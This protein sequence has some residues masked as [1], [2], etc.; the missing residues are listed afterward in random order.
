MKNDSAHYRD[1]KLGAALRELEVPEHRE[2][3]FADLETRLTARRRRP[4][5]RPLAVAAAAGVALLLFV[6]VGWPHLRSGPGV[7]SAAAVRAEVLKTLAGARTIRGDLVYSSFDLRTGKT[8]TR[9]QTFAADSRGDLRVTDVGGPSDLAYDAARGV[10]RAVTTSASIGAGRFFA[11]RVGVA[12]GPPDHGPSSF[13]L[14]RALGSVVRALAAARSPQVAEASYRGRAAWRLDTPLEPNTIFA[15]ADRLQVTVDRATGFPVHVL[16]TLRGA[17]R[18]E[19]RVDQLVVD[20]ALPPDTFTVDFPTGAD[21]LRTDEGF[22]HVS[23]D[24]AAA[25]VGYRPLGPADVPEGFGLTTIAVAKEAAPT[26]PGE[27]NPPSRD[28]VS[29][30]YRRGLDQFVVTTRRRGSETWSDPFAIEG[31]RLAPEH[32][33]VA[34]ARWDLVVNSRTVPHVWGVRNGL[35][36]TVSGD[37]TRAELLAVGRS[38]H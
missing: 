16:A 14:G 32:V 26:G 3:F 29:I 9:S 35:V 30:A 24:E 38:L 5:R 21:V 2:A 23:R 7:A 19:L 8:T 22:A 17:F 27:S 31:I 33:D 20:E 11:E 15:D 1:H 10:E 18:S 4:L 36:V 25:A 34:G 13:I 28:V 37:L 6:T 12:P